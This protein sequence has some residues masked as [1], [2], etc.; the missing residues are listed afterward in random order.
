[1]QPFG[2][3][4]EEQRRQGALSDFTIISNRSSSVPVEHQQT[5]SP[6]A[7][8]LQTKGSSLRVLAPFKHQNLPH[9]KAVAV[10]GLNHLQQ[11]V[12]TEFQR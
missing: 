2:A 9:F 6:K 1:M 4:G 7:E 5:Q 12:P 3:G 10:T 8:E 11:I